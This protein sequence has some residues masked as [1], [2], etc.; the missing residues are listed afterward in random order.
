MAAR[1]LLLKC[2]RYARIRS[3]CACIYV[4][5]V[6]VRYIELKL[7]KYVIA[8]NHAQNK[9]CLDY[10]GT[11]PSVSLCAC[12]FGFIDPRFSYWRY[13]SCIMT[14][15]YVAGGRSAEGIIVSCMDAIQQIRWHKDTLT[16]LIYE[17]HTICNELIMLLFV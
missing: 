12:V 7:L 2:R 3:F 5:G 15:P 17:A 8:L 13:S 14:L 6:G 10:T 9:D 4:R 1:H 16:H 11:E